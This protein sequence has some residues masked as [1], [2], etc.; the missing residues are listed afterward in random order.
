MDP[1]PSETRPTS[2]PVKIEPSAP[3]MSSDQVVA[4]WTPEADKL[5]E[6]W[7]NRAY[8]AQSAHYLMAERFTRW[9]YLLGIPV[10]ILS[11]V[12]GTA[13]FSN[14]DGRIKFGNWIIGSV[15]ILAAILS[16][17]QTFLRLSETATH[18]GVAA[19]W[20]SAIRRDA[21]ELMALPRDFRGDAKSCF[22]SIR[23]EMNKVGQKAPPLGERLWAQSAER[24]GVH[25]PPLPERRRR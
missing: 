20:Y 13:I 25:E 16:S 9:N 21:E 6:E 1:S 8:A 14:L 7:R 12:V 2:E 10:V 18:F 4:S 15:S 17:L 5:L 19:D 3:V 24:F 11:S 22:D 23:Q